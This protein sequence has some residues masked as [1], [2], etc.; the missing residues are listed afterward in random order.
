M[1]RYDS[2]EINK[3]YRTFKI[4]SVTVA[5]S[6]VTYTT[7]IDYADGT[8]ADGALFNHNFVVGDVIEVVGTV[9]NTATDTVAARDEFNGT[10]EV[11][12]KA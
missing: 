3:Y 5:G 6:N 12:A 7:G 9:S 1:V 11:T 8:N 2:G 4:R 10:F